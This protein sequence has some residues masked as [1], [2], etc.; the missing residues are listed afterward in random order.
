MK[1]DYNVQFP[2][3]LQSSQV[4]SK[5]SAA[6]P[7]RAGTGSQGVSSPTGD[8][9]LSLSNAHGEVQSLSAALQ[10]VPEVRSNR[11]SGLQ[12]QVRK[13]EY[14]PDSGKIADA[15]IAQQTKSQKA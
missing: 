2:D 4:S 15:L 1:I 9:T 11:V 10:Q 3:D 12:Y 13:G 7:S 8:D 14:Q 5:K 6:T